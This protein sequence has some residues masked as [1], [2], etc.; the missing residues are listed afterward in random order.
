M[1]N[2][3]CAECEDFDTCPLGSECPVAEEAFALHLDDE[4]AP[5]IAPLPVSIRKAGGLAAWLKATLPNYYSEKLEA[6]TNDHR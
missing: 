1:L 6:W 4:V 2:T 3:E 5:T